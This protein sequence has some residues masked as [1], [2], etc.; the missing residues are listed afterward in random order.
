VGQVLQGIKAIEPKVIPIEAAKITAQDRAAIAAVEQ[1]RKQQKR[2]L[3]FS[4]GSVISLLILVGVLV[5][6]LYSSNERTLDEQLDIPA[7][8]FLFANGETKNL[9]EFWIDKYEVTYGQY[10]KFVKFLEEHPTSEYDDPASR[11]SRP[12]RCTSPSTGTST[13]STPWPANPPIR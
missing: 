2:A 8:E 6:W 7:G 12:Q 1:A 13:S 4:I 3:Y 9:P 5:Y 10:S 11:A